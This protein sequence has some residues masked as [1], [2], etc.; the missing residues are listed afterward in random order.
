MY[1]CPIQPPRE[2][3][4]QFVTVLQPKS[5]FQNLPRIRPVIAIGVLQ[6]KEMRR[7]P[8]VRPAAPHQHG[9][10]PDSV[11]HPHMNL[12]RPAVAIRVLES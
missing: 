6:E 7:L 3:I 4:E 5:G 9:L 8:H 2:S 12:V 11:D 10:S 1:N